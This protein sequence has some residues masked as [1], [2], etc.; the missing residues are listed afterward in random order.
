[1]QK[2]FRASLIGPFPMDT[3]PIR[4]GF[5]CVH[6]AGTDKMEMW[7][8]DGTEWSDSDDGLGDLMDPARAS[9]WYGKM[10]PGDISA[11]D[12]DDGLGG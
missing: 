1:M 3:P 4:T 5:W 12:I 9:G 6:M 10:A 11:E 7:F 2:N 8:W